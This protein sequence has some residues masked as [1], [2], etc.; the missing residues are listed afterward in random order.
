MKLLFLLSLLENIYRTGGHP[1]CLDFRPP[2]KPIEIRFCNE[3]SQY[4]CCT[5]SKD[6]YL[7]REYQYITRSFYGNKTCF[8][9]VKDM[10]CLECNPYAAHVFDIETQVSNRVEKTFLFPGLCKNFCYEQFDSCQQ[11]F[12]QLFRNDGLISFIKNSSTADFCTWAEISDSSYCYPNLKSLQSDA[13]INDLDNKVILCVETSRES[14]SNPLFAT[15]SND[16]SH[17]LFIIEQRGTVFIVD[18]KGM[19]SKKP[20]LNITEKVL[21]SGYAWDERGLLCLVF[22]PK[23]KTNGRFYIYY[24][25][26]GKNKTSDRFD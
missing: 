13:K 20:F 15:H 12:Q 8:G 22:H 18:H 24:S 26:E 16:G 4:S 10:L 21:N 7:E 11:F 14:F 17:R 6:K 23:Y 2:F 1:Q 25:A 3:Y 19:K 9:S 5:F